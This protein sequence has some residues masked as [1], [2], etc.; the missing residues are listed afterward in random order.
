MRESTGVGKGHLGDS[1]IVCA[2]LTQRRSAISRC[3]GPGRCGQHVP[4]IARRVTSPT[5]L[6]CVLSPSQ[7]DLHK[8]TLPNCELQIRKPRLLG[9]QSHLFKDP[10]L[11][12]ILDVGIY[13]N[14]ATEA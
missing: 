11:M 8:D 14:L 7:Q 12:A 2:E 5:P 3:T 10:Q 1:G 6:T 13:I 9:T 4:A